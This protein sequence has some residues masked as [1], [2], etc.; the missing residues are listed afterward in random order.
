[1]N[2]NTLQKSLVHCKLTDNANGFSSGKII[3]IIVF[4]N[5]DFCKIKKG[6]VQGCCGKM[7]QSELRTVKRSFLTKHKK[8]LTDLRRLLE[9]FLIRTVSSESS[10]LTFSAV[11]TY[12]NQ[13]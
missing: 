5:F 4:W 11:I 12:S 7:H 3:L 1:M 6:R 2:F 10:W 9:L 8:L 13:G